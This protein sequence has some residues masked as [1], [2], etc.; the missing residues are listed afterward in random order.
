MAYAQGDF[1]SAK[2]RGLVVTFGLL[3]HPLSPPRQRTKPTHRGILGSARARV[4][5]GAPIPKSSSPN[6]T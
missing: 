4:L 6:L 2:A 3:F 1:G 5:G